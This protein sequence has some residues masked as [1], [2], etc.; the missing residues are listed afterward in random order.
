MTWVDQLDQRC[1]AISRRIALVAI[2]G[3]LIISGLTAL[4]VMLRGTA[5][6]PIPG[7][8][9]VIELI[10]AVA[11]AACLPAA[12][13]KRAALVVDLFRSRL[14]PRLTG[15]LELL[16]AGG[17]FIFLILLAWR[18]VLHAAD[19]T[20]QGA[21]TE[22]I[23]MSVAPFW[24][25]VCLF[26]VLCLPLQ[27]VSVIVALRNLATVGRRE[28]QRTALDGNGRAPHGLFRLMGRG[29]IP[30]GLVVLALA[31]VGA[32]LAS[33]SSG[34]ILAVAAFVAMLALS[35][36]LIPLAVSMGLVGLIGSVLIV[37]YTPAL[38]VLGSRSADML[39][40]LDLAAIPLFMMMGG[41]ASTAG[42]SSDV[43]RLAHAVLGRRPGG[44]A[45]ATIGGCAA[46]GAVTGSSLATAI[47]MGRIAVPEMRQRGYSAS[48][49]TG[50][51]A[52]GGTLGMLIPPSTIL[53]IYAV[54][55]ETSIGKLFIAAVVPALISVVFYFAAVKAYVHFKPE[56]APLTTDP[57][58][59]PIGPALL[60]CWAV[61]LLFGVVIGGI[62]GGAFTATEAAGIG[63]GGAFL[64]ALLRGR[65]GRGA[66]WD[67]LGDTA[68]ITAML[69]LIIFGAAMFS[70]LIGITQ[71]PDALVGGITDLGLPP[72]VIVFAILALYLFLGAVL[73]PFAMLLI[74]VPVV[75]PLISGLGYDL[76]WWGIITIMVVEIGLITPPIGMNVFIIKSI[77]PDVPLGAIFRGI[78]PFLAADIVK[79]AIL[80]LIPILTLWLPRTM[81]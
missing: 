81:E 62:Y 80:T 45:L 42:L 40:R 66:F 43:Y 74:T 48:L 5:N 7:F 37:G 58:S 2:L 3:M 27:A 70:F 15:V 18:L 29:A 67:V 72:L 1:V 53:V 57:E 35:F 51:I 6:M 59:E 36:L 13:S 19:K 69:Y 73:D 17:L 54:L 41:F 46:F 33:G 52:A 75:V 32:M 65:L 76:V 49:A 47:T 34:A 22:I 71:I 61:L 8:Y 56:A 55:T 44:L 31:A 77:V 39:A 24:W 78:L 10:I 23:A 16:G 38:H 26:V 20:D 25:A 79:L 28:H 9:E 64:I 11:I 14:G 12:I 4:D 21:A 30:V 63:A 50:S 60:R 68:A